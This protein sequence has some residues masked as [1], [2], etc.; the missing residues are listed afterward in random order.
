MPYPSRAKK[1]AKSVGLGKRHHSADAFK[2]LNEEQHKKRSDSAPPKSKDEEL[3]AVEVADV[4][5]D[6]P[7][8]NTNVPK[9]GGKELE[10]FNTAASIADEAVEAVVVKPTGKKSKL[11]TAK[12]GVSS[13]SKN[14]ELEK[15]EIPKQDDADDFDIDDGDMG[16]LGTESI[17]VGV[18][19][20]THLGKK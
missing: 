4:K 2:R 6:V 11:K 7:N 20:G 3:V 12:S 10:R 14:K 8:D 5:V 16:D 17:P 13:P 15:V 1:A 18:Q 19:K 9:R